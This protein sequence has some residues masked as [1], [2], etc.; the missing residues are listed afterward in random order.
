MDSKPP[1]H[2]F[3]KLG[4]CAATLR[5]SEKSILR[6]IQSGDLSGFRLRQGSSRW[7]VTK[8][9]LLKFIA[10]RISEAEKF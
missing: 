3:L 4:E 7:L 8:D 6:L 10:A 9:S 2:D 5:C 1:R